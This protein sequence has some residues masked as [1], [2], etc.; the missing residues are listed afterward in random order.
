MDVVGVRHACVHRQ[1]GQ[2]LPGFAWC[3][4]QRHSD[5]EQHRRDELAEDDDPDPAAVARDIEFG[6][7]LPLEHHALTRSR[8][9][10]QWVN[11][12]RTF[13]ANSLIISAS[14]SN[15]CASAND[16]MASASS[17]NA[18]RRVGGTFVRGIGCLVSMDRGRF[19]GLLRWQVDPVAI[20]AD[21][22]RIITKQGIPVDDGLADEFGYGC[23]SV[24]SQLPQAIGQVSWPAN[25]DTNGITHDQSGITTC[26]RSQPQNDAVGLDSDQM[27]FGALIKARRQ[28]AGL[29]QEQL[30]RLVP[31]IGRAGINAIEQ[32]YTKSLSPDVANEL[33]KVLP[34]S[35]PELLRAM[36]FNL[37]TVYTTL[38]ADL[39]REL[40]AA[41]EDVLEA[42]RL[43]LAG[44]RNQQQRKASQAGE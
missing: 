3:S 11:T 16:A 4:Q 38:D 5:D 33:V 10:V 18:R 40:E 21:Q 26:T 20:P 36:G 32:G 27:S 24:R 9:L 7:V 41:P 17:A 28:A 2:A 1:A 37:P 15:P 8:R 19:M 23:A 29:T 13:A 39:L 22:I 6:P 35:M 42:V 25:G 44:W 34:L 30:A 31:G 43:V 14:S 12:G